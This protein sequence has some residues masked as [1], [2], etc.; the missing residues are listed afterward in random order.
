MNLEDL[1]ERRR[2]E[3][4]RDSLGQLPESFYRDAA[5]YIS[6]LKTA[7]ERAANEADDPYGDPE[8]RRLTDELQSATEVVESLYERRVGKVVK[9]ASFAAAD[10]PHDSEGL[11]DEERALFDDL[12]ERIRDSRSQVLGALE[13]SGSGEATD[14]SA[15]PDAPT[16]APEPAPERREPTDGSGD[17]LP[18]SDDPAGMLAEAMGG[19]QDDDPRVDGGETEP[20]APGGEHDPVTSDERAAGNGRGPGVP[21][22][23]TA[24][25]PD[26]GA[27]PDDDP[28]AERTT[29]RITAD[30][31]EIYGVDDRSYRLEAEDVVSLPADNAAP[32]VEKDAAERL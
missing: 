5:D 7:R 2:H 3:R 20:P 10:M 4:E 19:G 11:T 32:L 17:P 21:D 27:R 31:G 1:R 6:G 29:V 16:E 14:R 30:V 23:E 12:V 25:R 9:H 15:A 18:A 22:D 26:A 13:E 28:A 8:V 24:E